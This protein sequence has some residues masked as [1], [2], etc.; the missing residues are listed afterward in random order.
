MRVV[1]TFATSEEHARATNL[2]DRLGLPYATISPEPAYARVGCPALVLEEEDKAAFLRAGGADVVTAGWVDF[3]EPAAP[4]PGT[5]PPQFSEDVMG[6][7]AIVLLAPCVADYRKLRLTAHFA[8]DAGPAMPY[9][10]A[11]SPQVSYMANV[12]VLSM[13]DGHRMLSLTRHRISVAKADDIV[14]AWACLERVRRQVNEV[15]ARREDIV[16]SDELRRRPSALE[17]YK[18]LPGT[19]CGACGLPSCTAFAWSVWRGD[20]DVRAC[21]PVFAGERRDLEGPLLAI[22]AGLGLTVSSDAAE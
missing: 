8:G 12:P 10:N 11:V 21:L 5:A 13:M 19:N 20:E 3:R 1:T 16:P 22:C 9:V 7:V 18:R 4:V 2:L 6:R 15:W 17:I 14:D